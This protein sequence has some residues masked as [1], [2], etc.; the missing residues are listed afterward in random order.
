MVC[1]ALLTKT[2]SRTR[3]SSDVI[4]PK[5]GSQR[6]DQ[7][8]MCNEQSSADKKGLDRVTVEVFDTHLLEPAVL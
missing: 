8:C 3:P 5:L 4:H 1:L 6:R 7:S 2:S